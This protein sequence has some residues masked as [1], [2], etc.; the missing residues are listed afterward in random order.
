MKADTNHGCHERIMLFSVD[1]QQMQT[2][3]IQDSVIDTFGSCALLI[4][5]F[6]GIRSVGH[7]C[8]NADVPFEFSFY[9]SPVSRRRTVLPAFGCMLFPVRTAPHQAASGFVKTIRDHSFAGGTDRRPIFID[10]NVIVDRFG[11]SASIIKV[12]KC[13]YVSFPE[14]SVSRQVVHGGVE[15]YILYGKG[16]HVLF[17][18]MEGD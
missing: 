9:D 5:L 4:D 6:I 12:N 7:I 14:Q 2:V 1:F 13:P 10:G 3:V 16:R 11:M 18:L 17:Q 15:T 8:V